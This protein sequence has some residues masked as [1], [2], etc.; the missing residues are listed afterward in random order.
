MKVS[1]VRHPLE[2]LGLVRIERGDIRVERLS[3]RAD[4]AIPFPHRHDFYQLLWMKKSSGWHEIDFQR[5]D[6][7]AQQMFVMKPGQVHSWKMSSQ[8]E[9]IIIEFSSESLI[10]EA[11]KASLEGLLQQLP[12]I[13]NVKDPHATVINEQ[14]LAMLKEFDGRK[15]SYERILQ[16][17]LNILILSLV[18][19]TKIKKP[20]VV[21]PEVIVPQ[22]QKLV[23]ANF[24][25]HHGLEFYA[26]VLK[27]SPRALTMR[28]SRHLKKAG[29]QIIFDRLLLEAKR[30]LAYSEESVS[31][32]GYSLG[33]ED[34]NHFSRF[35]KTQ[36][37]ETALK[38]RE[39]HWKNK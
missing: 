3:H 35:F 33:F 24:R 30:L 2:S 17:Y 22:F 16:S 4:P 39:R 10:A 9:G 19:L 34:A 36:S 12:D 26:D 37:Q 14:A 23:E 11:G 27:I 25:Q 1:P 21:E 8:S 31:V 29:R 20:S 5:H 13:L 7:Q 18:R 28:T 6:V 38:F 15:I 32:I